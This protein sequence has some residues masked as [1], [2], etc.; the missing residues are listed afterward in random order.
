MPPPSFHCSPGQVGRPLVGRPILFIKGVELGADEH[1]LVGPGAVAAPE[2]LAGRDIQRGQPAAHA[3]FAPRDTDHDLVLDDQRRHRGGLADVDVP[4][5]GA[6]DLGAGVGVDR[7]RHGV[8]EVVDDLSVGVRRA[9]VDDVAAG[10]ADGARVRVWLVDELHRSGR[11]GEI[12]GD[13]VVGIGRDDVHRVVD[14]QRLPF[15]AMGDAGRDG[16]QH[17][18]IRNV[19]GLELRER[20]EAGV[21]V[22]AARQ[23]PVAVRQGRHQVDPRQRS[24]EIG[25]RADPLGREHRWTRASLAARSAGADGRKNGDQERGG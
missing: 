13:Q 8:E 24:A 4:D 5:L 16:G 15:V 22:I 20:A 7:H 3:H 11:L 14:N 17:P 21:G 2:L 9:P 18:E 25:H 6:P 1:I 19:V 12:D 23:P 10:D